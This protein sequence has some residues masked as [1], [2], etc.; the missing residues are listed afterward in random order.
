MSAARTGRVG[1]EFVTKG[2][3]QRS[4][5][6]DVNRQI[7]ATVEYEVADVATAIAGSATADTLYSWVRGRGW[8]LN[9]VAAEGICLEWM[10]IKCA[11]GDALQDLNDSAIVEDLHREGRVFAR[12]MCAFVSGSRQFEFEFYNV[13]LDL[14]DELRMVVRPITGTAGAT[15]HTVGVLEWR[16]VGT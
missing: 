8:F 11:S 16:Q 9:S 15:F 10:I 1:I 5:I 13:K 2:T 3:Y 12:D 4:L 6:S 14:G 7:A